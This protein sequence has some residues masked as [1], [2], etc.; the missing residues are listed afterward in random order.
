MILV[1]SVIFGI[2]GF[3]LGSGVGFWVGITFGP[4][5]GEEKIRR[6]EERVE[7]LLLDRP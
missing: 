1:A 4:E 6:L 7:T 2:G 5:D 3:L